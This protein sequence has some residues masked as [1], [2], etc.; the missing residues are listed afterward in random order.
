[1]SLNSDFTPKKND[2]ATATD[3]NYNKQELNEDDGDF[4]HRRNKDYLIRNP[5]VNESL[6]QSK[7]VGPNLTQKTPKSQT[8]N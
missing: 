7:I 6:N 4:S 1:M 8:L 5:E 2:Q 3:Y